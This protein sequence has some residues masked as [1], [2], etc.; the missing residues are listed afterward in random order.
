MSRERGKWAGRGIFMLIFYTSSICDVT[1]ARRRSRL[2]REK[3]SSRNTDDLSPFF[4]WL[5]QQAACGIVVSQPGIESVPP[6]VQAWG[7]DH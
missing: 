5:H 6:T 1:A 7:P 3:C 2:R 4:F